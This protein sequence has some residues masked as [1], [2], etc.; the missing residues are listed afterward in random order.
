MGRWDACPAAAVFFRGEEFS[1]RTFTTKSLLK[2]RSSRC[3]EGDGPPR[4]RDF[5]V[6]GFPPPLFG[7]IPCASRLPGGVED[8]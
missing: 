2:L 6:P 8:R 3:V 7:R 1:L 5:A 4:E